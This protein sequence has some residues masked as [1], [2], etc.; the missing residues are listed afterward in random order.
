MDNRPPRRL[1][2]SAIATIA[3]LILAIGGGT[4]WVASNSRSPAP[5][6][7]ATPTSSSNVTSSPTPI[8]TSN[9]TPTTPTSTPSA[10]PPEVKQQT[11]EI[12]WLQSKNDK[13][14]L[15]ERPVTLDKATSTNPNAILEQA[16][17]RLLAGPSNSDREISTT[18]P[19]GTKLQSVKVENDTVKV[20]LSPEFTS[21]G[22][23]AS[24][25]GRLG[26]VIYTATSLD[27]NAK[28]LISVDGK[29]LETLGGEGLELEQPLTRSSF[30][31]NFPL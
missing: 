7:T 19:Q 2:N 9:P 5:A 21:G 8:A 12:Y 24:M 3:G 31:K 10:S 4:V 27:P 26:Q 25:T 11:A 14:E 23:S 29:L 6:P 20:D 30:Q 22:G 18:I 28:V 13:F 17:M 1:S 15:V 16:F